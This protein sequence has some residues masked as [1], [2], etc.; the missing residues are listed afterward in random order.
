M[1]SLTFK[2]DTAVKTPLNR[3]AEESNQGILSQSGL[4]NVAHTA[5][6]FAFTVYCP[7]GLLRLAQMEVLAVTDVTFYTH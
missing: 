6:G 7:V 1:A 5:S 4:V 2:Q 3:V